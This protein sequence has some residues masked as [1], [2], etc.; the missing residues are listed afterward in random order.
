MTSG[1][2]GVSSWKGI[3][4]RVKGQIETSVFLRRGDAAIDAAFEFPDAW[5]MDFR[6]IL[7][8]GP[9]LADISALLLRIVTQSGGGSFQVGG[10][11]TASIPLV[12]GMVL[13]AHYAGEALNGFF[14]RKSRKK[15]DLMQRIEGSLTDQDVVLV[16][17]LMNSGNS[18]L[19]QVELLETLGK[20]VRAVCVILRFRDESFYK[21]LT[22]RGITLLTLFTLDDFTSTPGLKHMLL[23]K[24]PVPYTP[25]DIAWVFES[26]GPAHEYVIPKSA[27]LLYKGILY[28]GSDNGT[29]WAIDAADARVRWRRKVLHGAQRKRIF[30]SPCLLEDR[31][32]FGGY[33]GNFYAL[34]ALS[35]KIRWVSLDA[36]WIGSS[37]TVAQDLGLV[38]VGM[39]FGFWKRQG[40]IAAFRAESGERVWM[41][42]LPAYVHASPAYS[43]RHRLVI[44]GSNDGCIYGLSATTGKERWRFDTGGEVKAGCAVS[45]DE[46]WVVAGSFNSAYAVLDTRTGAHVATLA[47][48]EANY[49]TPVWLDA[50]TF[51]CASLDKRVYAYH[52]PSHTTRWTFATHGRIFASPRVYHRCVYIGNNEGVLYVLDAE[53]GTCL[54]KH[55]LSERVTNA[56]VIDH[57]ER[58]L[59]IPTVANQIIKAKIP[60]SKPL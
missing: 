1:G 25:L 56:V 58:V 10:L 19:A 12:A 44:C 50:D 31:V 54:S 15:S 32:F 4:Q 21:E 55:F 29:F 60:A 35:G 7:L 23:G 42:P 34:D 14:I 49:S 45:P 36:D 37:P 59:Y 26:P 2:V 27:P 41:T 43:S 38:F 5:I 39:E 57:E 47:T 48:Q 13:T 52:V 40:G 9:V 51:V 33:D 53:T 11:E 28:F 18:L 8:R 22:S 46:R 6:R 17:D 24:T 3:R 20:K 30:S 16:D